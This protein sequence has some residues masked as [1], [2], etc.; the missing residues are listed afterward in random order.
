MSVQTPSLTHVIYNAYA[1]ACVQN[2]LDLL[3]DVCHPDVVLNSSCSWGVVGLENLKAWLSSFHASF[4]PRI[5][6]VDECISGDRAWVTINQH[7]KHSGA[8]FFG[9][10]LTGASGTSIE[11]FILRLR[12]GKVSHGSPR[13]S[14]ITVSAGI[15]GWAFC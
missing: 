10:K 3:D 6:Q 13:T 14:S 5:D 8:D 1:N 2:K 7:W 15:R 4:Q 11:V 12:E 9:I